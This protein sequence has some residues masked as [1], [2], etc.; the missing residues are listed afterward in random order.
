MGWNGMEFTRWVM[1][2]CV[3]MYVTPQ[4][5]SRS[6][7]IPSSLIMILILII[8]MVSY[9]KKE[10]REE[11]RFISQGEKMKEKDAQ[12]RYTCT[13]NTERDEM[14]RL[15]SDTHTQTDSNRKRKRQNERQ[16]ETEEIS[17]SDQEL[18]RR[19]TDDDDDDTPKYVC[20][21]GWLKKKKKKE[22]P[23]TKQRMIKRWAKVS[24]G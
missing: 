19:E 6:S 3:C 9:Q 14:M 1:K 7:S 10:E 24:L 22:P 21:Y 18:R 12:T 23:A 15:T 4:R 17:F 2:E 5:D 20:M 11:M 13:Q 8:L 16:K